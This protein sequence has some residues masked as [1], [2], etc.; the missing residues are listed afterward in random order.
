VF[1]QHVIAW[2]LRKH[3]ARPII[4]DPFALFS[5][6]WLSRTF[7][8][9]VLIMIRHP[10]A[11]CSSLKVK[12]WKF[13]FN[14]L[15]N[16]PNLMRDYLMPF[17]YEIRNYA[18][19]RKDIIDQGILLWN[20]L[21]HTIHLFRTR[22]TDWLFVRHEDLSLRPEEVFRRIFNAVQLPFSKKT[23]TAIQQSSGPHNS[24]EQQPRKEYYRNSRKNVDNW[25]NRLTAA[26]ITRIRK[27]TARV[28]ARFYDDNA[29]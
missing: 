27:G 29:W 4:K 14:H 25:K 28:A 1:K 10:A 26:E 12:D 20:C 21:H 22:H 13:N 16:Q 6:E 23:I 11:F 7:N 17:N 15:L 19:N 5:A 24:A 3:N 2:W 8:M 9:N 18:R